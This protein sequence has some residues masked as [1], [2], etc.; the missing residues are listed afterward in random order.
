MLISTKHTSILQLWAAMQNVKVWTI[1]F[2]LRLVGNRFNFFCLFCKLYFLFLTDLVFSCLCDSSCLVL[3]VQIFCVTCMYVYYVLYWVPNMHFIE[4]RIVSLM[5]NWHHVF[6][7]CDFCL[8]L[9]FVSFCLTV[10]LGSIVPFVVC[11]S[12]LL[13]QLTLWYGDLAMFY[14]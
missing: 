5:G 7:L 13:M 14:V 3:I 1:F 8:L 9:C 4:P 2:M 12:L 10:F 11:C 6:G